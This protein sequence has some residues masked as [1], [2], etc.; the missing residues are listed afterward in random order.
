MNITM[1]VMLHTCQLTKQLKNFFKFQTKTSYMFY[2]F[3]WVIPWILC[4]DVSE[5]CVC[6][7]FIGSAF[8][9]MPPMKME[10]T[11]WSE[12]LACKI[13][14]PGNHPKERTQHSE[15][16]KCLK[17]RSYNRVI[18]NTHKGDISKQCLYNYTETQLNLK[19]AIDN[20]LLLHT[21]QICNQL[22]I[23]F[24]IPCIM[25]QLSQCKPRNNVYIYI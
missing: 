19:R 10:V 20:Y 9:L 2:S 7:I 3:C 11:K 24:S 1:I 22:C 16:S 25:I 5:H 15:H 17:S 21:E 6:S 14:M 8:L 18:K 4:A 12:T 23:T 13:Q